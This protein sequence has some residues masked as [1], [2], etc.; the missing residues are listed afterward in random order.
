MN[1]P[2]KDLRFTTRRNGGDP[3]AA[4][5][6]YPRLLR[7]RSVLPKVAIAVEYFESMLGRERRGL[8]PEVLVHFFGDHK[9]ARCVVASMAR[10]YRYR[11]PRLEEVVSRTALRR[12]QRQGL[13]TPKALRLSLYDQLNDQGDGFLRGTDRDS[14]LG[15]M[16]TRLGL[17]RG[18]LER[19]L[20]LDAEE[21]AVLVRDGPVPTPEDVVAQYNFAILSTLLRHAEHVD[22]MLVA[23]AGSASGRVGA[24]RQLC[25]VNDVDAQLGATGRS[26]G[27]RLVGRQDALG[28]WSRHGR[29]LARTVTQV[30]ERGQA[31]VVD[32][33]ASVVVRGRRLSL[34]LTDEVLDLLGRRTSP[35]A[36][37][38]SIAG[39]D[40]A[41]VA[42]AVRAP[43][44]TRRGRLP[45]RV[46]TG[47]AA[48]DSPPDPSSA[49]TEPG[50]L[51][52]GGATGAGGE[53][54]RGRTWSLRRSPDASAW[55]EG[56]LI[57]DVALQFG[58]QRVLV[59]AVRSPDHAARLAAIAGA[60]GG[61]AAVFAGDPRTLA[62]LTAVGV[63][64]LA[65]PTF[66]V[67]AVAEALQDTLTAESP[68]PTPAVRRSKAAR[69][70]A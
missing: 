40:E 59:C 36:G 30:L 33:S 11:S 41:A 27:L 7:D 1:L 42:A 37:W 60:A 64:T 69:P 57:P 58:E 61:A 31:E 55:A 35:G 45:G 16:E 34:S 43:Y 38:E 39:W 44:P 8:D 23:T 22:L 62:P 4:P 67:A 14:T 28:L 70:A 52:N 47:G 9:L 51:N 10:S 63:R 15:R 26:L 48:P 25:A 50:G 19:L 2:L 17:R 18:E 54:A 68:V 53:A 66:D 32:G 56:V 21:H 3:D 49:G 29:R 13:L 6:V 65:L 5:T 46:P 24:I 20:Y 12:L